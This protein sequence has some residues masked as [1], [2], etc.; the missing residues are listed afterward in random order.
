M[1]VPDWLNNYHA[2]LKTIDA[3]LPETTDAEDLADTLEEIANQMTLEID[4]E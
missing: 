3:W 1:T 2:L 4:L